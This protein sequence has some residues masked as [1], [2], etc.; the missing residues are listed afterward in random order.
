MH[1]TPNGDDYEQFTIVKPIPHTDD[2][3]SDFGNTLQAIGAKS[4]LLINDEHRVLLAIEFSNI[5]H[6]G[7]AQLTYLRNYN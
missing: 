4:L 1:F 6:W 5:K 7:I 3:F 2:D